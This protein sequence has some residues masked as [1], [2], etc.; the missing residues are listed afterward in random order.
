MSAS[1]QHHDNDGN[2]NMGQA[3]YDESAIVALNQNVPKFRLAAYAR[4]VFRRLA[5]AL[6]TG[7]LLN[8][9][10]VQ[11]AQAQIAT[12]GSGR[13]LNEIVWMSWGTNGAQINQSGITRTTT[14]NIGG[15]ILSVT[16]SIASISD[17]VGTS[18]DPDLTAYRPGNWSGDALDDLYN[19]GGANGSN[20]MVI[21]LSNRNDTAV[22]SFN[23]NCSARLG[24]TG[25]AADPVYPLEGLVFADAEQSA[26]AP[27]EY[28]TAT[29]PAGATFRLIDRYRSAGCSSGGDVTV[30]G[31][32]TVFNLGGSNPTCSTGPAAVGFIDGATSGQVG[33]HGGGYSAIAL[34]V[35]ISRAD[36]SDA[37]TSYGTAVHSQN[38][39]FTGG[40]LPTGTS[41]YMTATMAN[42]TLSNLRLGATID[43]DTASLAGAAAT[44]DDTD[45]SDDEDSIASVTNVVLSPGTTH[46]QSGVSCSGTGFVYGFIDFNRDGDFLDSGETSAQAS[47]SGGT[48]SLSW[49]LPAAGQLSAGTSYLRVRMGSLAANVSVPSGLSIDGE[50][51][52]FTVTQT[53]PVADVAITKTDNVTTVTSG[54]TTTYVLTVTNNGPAA[55]NGAV[56][57]DTPGTGITCPAAN[58]VT[59]A[60][61]GVP[62]GSYTIANLTGAGI[63]LGTL[64]NGQSATLTYTC[65]VN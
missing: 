52:D 13:F 44:G 40:V 21:G 3:P 58:A 32:G 65:Q 9:A 27:N 5:G 30:S 47:C 60:G 53:L 14:A 2:N 51:E 24:S 15:Q 55:V 36:S 29:I 1:H 43:F 64:T 62:A 34:G 16:C 54:G 42:L 22:I 61:N 31:G 8:L 33:L 28:V 57:T 59:I 19:I 6:T 25:T 35:L 20:T 7:L 50:V 56:V 41:N 48:A 18:N 26:S 38:P 49:T 23:F 63:A 17:T 4:G 46:T 37:P 12:G 39:V 45:G 10:L 11:P